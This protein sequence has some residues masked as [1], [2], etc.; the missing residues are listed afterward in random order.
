MQ[1]G[2]DEWMRPS[3]HSKKFSSLLRIRQTSAFLV[4]SRSISR[5][6]NKLAVIKEKEPNLIV[7]DEI[8]LQAVQSKIAWNS[9]ISYPYPLALFLIISNPF[10]FFLNL[11]SIVTFRYSQH[12]G[13]KNWTITCWPAQ[14]SF[15]MRYS[16]SSP[17]WISN[18]DKLL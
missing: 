3:R 4:A 7:M 14:K 9:L 17:V 2:T 16:C 15:E 11:N 6:G 12:N 1:F 10:Q 13:K 5:M 18:L 8:K